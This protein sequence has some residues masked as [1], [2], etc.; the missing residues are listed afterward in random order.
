M[1]YGALLHAS[2]QPLARQPT[3]T[4]PDVWAQLVNNPA[5]T[6]FIADVAADFV[7]EANV[8]RNRSLIRELPVVTM[9]IA[10]GQNENRMSFAACA[11][12][13]FG[14]MATNCAL[15]QRAAQD[16]AGH[17]EI[18]EELLGRSYGLPSIHLHG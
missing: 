6:E 4:S 18:A 17:R 2:L 3:L 13:T 14:A 9:S 15:K 1:E 5:E 7:G 10:D 16:L 8:D 12:R 11:F